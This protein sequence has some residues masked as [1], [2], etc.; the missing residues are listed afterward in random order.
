MTDAPN[1]LP[2]TLRS[3]CQRIQFHPFSPAELESILRPRSI[4]P[5]R[6]L[7]LV[8]RIS[9]GSLGRALNLDLQQYR[10]ARG[11]MV[12][13]IRACAGALSYHR[14]LRITEPLA[15]PRHKGQFE[16]KT[17]VLY[18]LLRDLML[19]QLGAPGDNLTNIDLQSELSDI[20]SALT[21]GQIVDAVGSLDLLMKGP[22]AQ[23]QQVAG[24]GPISFP[25]ERR[26]RHAPQPERCLVGTCGG[27]GPMLNYRY[28]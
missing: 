28:S 21:F 26:G 11:E 13:A 24:S 6:D 27:M 16:F 4:H 8:G 25:T 7:P 14:A 2:G 9:R 17:G 12:E 20:G 3:R 18:D 5:A 15:S 19:I 22:G 1:D 10:E 23:S